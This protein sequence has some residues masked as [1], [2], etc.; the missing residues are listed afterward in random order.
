MRLR[1]SLLVIAVLLTPAC[2]RR[3]PCGDPSSAPDC[4]AWSIFTQISQPANN[5]TRDVQWESWIFADQV[6]ADPNKPPSWPGSEHR[7]KPLARSLELYFFAPHSDNPLAYEVRMNRVAFD[8]IVARGLWNYLGLEK[9]F[10]GPKIDFPQ[11]SI[12]IKA[13]W[14]YIDEG[15][16]PAYHW[17]Y[18]QGSDHQLRLMGLDALHMT[19]RVL[20]NWLWATWKHKW[21]KDRTKDSFGFPRGDT[22][23]SGLQEMFARNKVPREM[24]NY[25]LIG[26]QV[27]FS[28]A[29][30]T[31]TIL[32]NSE[33][34]SG[35]EIMSSCIT[36]HALARFDSFG[37]V[38]TK[39]DQC[40]KDCG[41]SCTGAAP[42]ACFNNMRQLHFVWSFLGSNTAHPCT[43]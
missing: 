6:F 35:F 28:N 5:G 23:S 19:S 14:I 3:T 34:E 4:M 38:H 12:E 32:G 7:E 20:P 29:D 13:K 40:T 22:M 24:E 37:C 8:F 31:P 41:A 21:S 42:V 33:I 16:K 1:D 27:E 30:G 43:N 26:T 25:R 36:C 9:A 18:V 17:Q 39:D 2:N 10:D 15:Q 11:E